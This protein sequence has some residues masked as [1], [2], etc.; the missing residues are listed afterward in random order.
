MSK[1]KSF[2]LWVFAFLFTVAF[3][4]YQRYTGPTYPVTGHI[5]YANTVIKYK[6]LRT[7]DASGDQEIKI[8]VPD[9]TIKGRFESKRYKKGDTWEKGGDTL[10]VVE[11]K[12]VGDELI[13]I[14]PHQASAGKVFYKINV[15][16]DKDLK[17]I[18]V[19][20][21]PTIIRFKGQVPPWVIWPH[22]LLIFAA[23]LFSSRTG[24]EAIFKGSHIFSFSVATLI[25]LAIAGGILGP[26]MQKY[27]FGAYWTGWPFGH[28]LTDNKTAVALLFWAI[29]VFKLWK[30]KQNRKWAIIASVILIAVYLIP[31][32]ALGSELDY[33]QVP[34][35]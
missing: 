32:S 11:M 30:N 1:T 34:K 20:P 17:G 2:L 19:K 28:D 6:L 5:T 23:F 10:S 35:K 12:R 31:H 29:A 3:V 18:Y 26:L 33:T 13:G 16:S 15:Y 27:A 8:Q 14:V 4:I 21:E 25:L 9:Q 24:L 7:S 22:V